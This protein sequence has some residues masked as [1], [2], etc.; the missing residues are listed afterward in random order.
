MQAKTHK[1][2]VLVMLLLA[3]GAFFWLAGGDLAA[4]ILLLWTALPLYASWFLQGK[5]LEKGPPVLTNL[6]PLWLFMLFSI[7]F[8]LFY[9]WTWWADWQGTRTGSSTSALI[10]VVFPA[11]SLVIGGAGYL[12]GRVALR[13][14][15]ALR[16]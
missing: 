16:G 8:S 1:R 5:A 12:C 13:V 7:T 11:W 10:F 15:R 9:H 14:M 6:L 2:L 4:L 3:A